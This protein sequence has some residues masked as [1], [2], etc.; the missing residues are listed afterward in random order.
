VVGDL[1]SS[2]QRKK[3]KR[4]RAWRF[5]YTALLETVWIRG[6][7]RSWKRGAL[8]RRP[9]DVDAALDAISLI[10]Y[11]HLWPTQKQLMVLT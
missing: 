1:N 9:P 5:A 11:N 2:S 6:I 4:E 3:S 7:A 8:G 10:L